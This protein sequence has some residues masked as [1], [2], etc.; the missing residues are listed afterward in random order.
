MKVIG[1]DPGYEQ[2]HFDSAEKRGRLSERELS[3]CTIAANA[4]AVALLTATKRG[5]PVVFH[6]PT[7]VKAAVTGSG[8]ADK[9]QVTAMVTRKDSI[10]SALHRIAATRSRVV[11]TLLIRFDMRSKG[12]YG[13]HGYDYFSYGGQRDAS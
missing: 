3:F 5:I 7:E 2:R 10:Q 12:E 9:A 13:Y 8:R 6:T 4:T 1:I 11:G